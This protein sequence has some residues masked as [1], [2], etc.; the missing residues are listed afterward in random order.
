MSIAKRIEAL[1]VK[2]ARSQALTEFVVYGG[3]SGALGREHAL[4]GRTKIWREPDETSEEFRDRV[5][6][7]A[8]AAGERVVTFKGLHRP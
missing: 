4:I 1:E 2:T 7:T 3:F 6:R 8:R 5:R